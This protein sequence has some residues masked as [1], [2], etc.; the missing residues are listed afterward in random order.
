MMPSP[1]LATL[2]TAAALFA[3]PPTGADAA[4]INA[5]VTAN[6]VKPLQFTARRDL[7]FGTILLSAGM[8]G[9]A[10]VTLSQGGVRSCP[11]SVTCTGAALPAIFN[12]QGTNKQV[13]RISAMASDLVNAADGRTLRFTPSAPTSITLTNSGAPGLDFNVGG[14][15]SVPANATDG[16]YSG[17]VEITVDNQ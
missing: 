10:T 17:T 5:Q 15:I 11:A 13:V 1:R 2:L 12:V 8:T 6:V 7:D 14:S 4:V 16:L 9:P 3:A